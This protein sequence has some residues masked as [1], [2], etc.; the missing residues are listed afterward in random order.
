MQ[1]S[2]GP[3]T[4]HKRIYDTSLTPPELFQFIAD[5]CFCSLVE[6][7]GEDVYPCHWCSLQWMDFY[8][9]V[10]TEDVHLE[11]LSKYNPIK[12]TANMMILF[13]RGCLLRYVSVFNLLD[14]RNPKGMV[15]KMII[16]WPPWIITRESRFISDAYGHSNHVRALLRSGYG[17]WRSE[18]ILRDPL[19]GDSCNTTW[20]WF[21][22]SQNYL[23]S[24]E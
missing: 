1:D 11:R 7:S 20:S 12:L 9:P 18:V 5:Q 17:E 15:Y 14:S 16:P 23:G 6:P 13:P 19:W 22:Q 2:R 8:Q 4:R 3:I 24:G 10:Y 21:N